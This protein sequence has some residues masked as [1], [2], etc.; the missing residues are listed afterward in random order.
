[1]PN[2]ETAADELVRKLTSVESEVQEAHESFAALTAQVATLGDEVDEHWSELVRAVG[3]LVAKAQAEQEALARETGESAQAV[4]TLESTAQR[5]EEA[6]ASGLDA[7][8]TGTRQLADQVREHRGPVESASEAGEKSLQAL[9][10]QAEAL[11]TQLEQVLQ[12]G[13]EFLTGEVA[14]ELEAMRDAI[15]D[16]FAEMRTTLVE[17][18]AGALQ[19]AYDEWSSRLDEV[20]QTVE[21]EGFEAARENAEEVATWALAECAAGHQAEF[22]RL[23]EVAEVVRA[24]LRTLTEDVAECATDVGE[25]GAGALEEALEQT[26]QALLGMVAALDACRGQMGSYSFV[27]L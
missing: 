1:M 24:A 4:A 10:Q 7:G 17:E 2:L 6:A 9:G 11:S 16:R 26:Q 13:R 8:E 18:C 14:E 5:A 22:D 15:A 27:D 25:E 21:S 20:L 23:H 3:E 12:E 19:T